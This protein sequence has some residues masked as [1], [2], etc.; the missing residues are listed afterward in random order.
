MRPELPYLAAGA[1][2][3]IGG[4]RREGGIPSNALPAVV[5][6]VVLVIA[7]STSTGSAIAPLVRAVGIVL[8][9]SA[10]IAAAKTPVKKVT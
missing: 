3:L 5:G 10:A 6:T 9:M 8:A 2:S 1:I 4:A 7:A